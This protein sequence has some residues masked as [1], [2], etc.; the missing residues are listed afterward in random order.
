[1]TIPPDI[2]AVALLGW[3][4]YPCS[5]KTKAACFK[6][7]TDRA[8]CDLDVI[9]GWVNEFGACNW[10]VVMGPSRIWALDCDVPPGH[11]HDGVVNFTAL[12]AQNSPLP[13]RPTARSGGGGVVVFFAHCGERII[14]DGG[15]PALGIDP[16]RGRQSQTIPPSIHLVTR[17]PYRWVAPPWDVAPPTA[18]AWLLHACAPPPEPEWK[19][20]PRLPTT[21]LARRVLI[22]AIERITG[23]TEGQRNDCLNR[24]GYGVA[25]FVAAGL[26]GE[27][28]AVEAL[29]AAARQ[30][31]L[32]HLEIKATLRSAFQS[33]FRH[34]AEVR[35]HV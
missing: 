3:H 1:M 29:Y 19:K 5:R 27:Q 2:E 7:P 16:R 21:D 31:G 9:A 6:N 34:P 33:G 28:D 8:S 22:R 32:P 10:R 17:K 25:R 18:P 26:L 11:P 4:L 12:V 35:G 13:R 23:A 24:A 15:H 30:T 20:T 14:G